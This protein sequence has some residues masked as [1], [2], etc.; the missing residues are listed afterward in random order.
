MLSQI[1]EGVISKD[2]GRGLFSFVNNKVVEAE[3][4]KKEQD[5]E[6]PIDL[7]TLGDEND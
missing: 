4:V 6:I 5:E 1:P 3:K 7:N 2:T